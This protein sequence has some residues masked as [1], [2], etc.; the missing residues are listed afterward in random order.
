MLSLKNLAR[1]ELSELAQC[2]LVTPYN[3]IDLGQHW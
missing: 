3:D 2:D 1:K